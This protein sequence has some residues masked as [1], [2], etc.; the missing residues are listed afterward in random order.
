MK[1]IA[2]S[3]S[4]LKQ[5]AVRLVA[6]IFPAIAPV[7]SQP[8][9]L[10][11][12]P[13][14][15]PPN[16]PV[17]SQAEN[18]DIESQD[19]LHALFEGVETGIFIIDPETHTLVDANSIAARMV[20]APREKI[21]GSLCHKFVCPAEKGRC[22]VT[23]LGQTV[24][25]SERVLLTADGERRAIIK[26]VRRVVVAGRTQLL[27]SFL[28]ITERKRAETALK[29]RTAYL[30]SLIEV[31]P[32]GIVVLDAEQHV[33]IL[34]AAFEQLFH[35]TR[36]EAQG[37]KLTDLIIPAELESEAANLT[38][39]CL[40]Q[41]SLKTTTRRRRKDGTQVDVRVFAAPLEVDGKT[42]GFLALYEDITAQVHAEKVVAERHRLAD[43]AAQVGA[44]L[45][46]ADDLRQGLQNCAEIL[47]RILDVAFARV[48]TVNERENVLELQASAGMY[49]HLDGPHARVPVGLYK[50]GRIAK[51]GEAHLSNNVLEDTWMA[52]PAWARREGMVAFA[53]YPL[54]VK[55]RVSG[56]IAAFA[57][58][59]LTEATFQA[60]ASVA[61]SIAQ[62]IER[63]RSEESLRDSEDRFR[64]AF[65]AAP[66]G[67]CMTAPDGRF[68][69]ANAALC[70]MLGY[71]AEELMAGAWQQVTHPDDLERSR[72]AGVQ[73]SRGGSAA[74]ELEKRYIQKNGGIV[75][76]RV[77]ILPVKQNH[78]KTSHFITQIED[79]TLRK[80][81]EK[82]QAFLVSLVESS[83]DAIIGKSIDGTVLSW[84]HGAQQLYGYS[85]EEM[86][87]KSITMLFP[88]DRAEEAKRIMETVG[89][90]KQVSRYDTV[91]VRK[92]GTRVDV[93]LTLSPV[94]DDTGK[95][96]GIATIAHD[97][98]QRKRREQQ[99]HLQTA[100]LESAANGIL[101][102]DSRGII[103]WVNPA[104]TRLTGYSAEEVLG[105]TPRALKSG[106][107]GEFYYRDMWTTIL[108]GDTWHG[109]IVNRRKDGTLY[110]E[111]MTITP[112]RATDGSVH[113]FVAIKQDISE[114]KRSQEELLFKSTLL[115][116][117][118][119]TTIDGILVIDRKG[120]R[121]QSNRHFAEIFNIPEELL[122]SNDDAPML[123][124]VV[125]Q[126]QNPADFLERVQY[127]YAHE[128]EKA[129]D[130]VKFEDGRCIDR[131]SAPL[132]DPSGRYYGRI[133]Y[134]RDIT[135][136]KQAEQALRDNEQ[137]YREL[138]ENA[139]EIIF[140]SDLDGRF[141]SV[142]LAGQQ[143]FG[144]TQEEAAE[145]DVWRLTAPEYW[146]VLKRN[147]IRM[148]AGEVDLTYE[149]EATAKDGHRVRL[150][151]KPRIIY[152]GDKPVGIQGIARNITGRDIAEMELRQAQKLESVGRLASGIAHEINTPIQFVG[153]NTR[154]LE[155]SFAS[156][157]TLL[158]KF[159]ELRD[160]AAS[161]AVSPYLLREV[162]R[163]E[164]ESDFAYLLDETPRAIAQTM[165]GVNRVATIVRA[166]K[167][168]AHPESKEMAPADL[169][170]AIRST[171]TVARNEWKYVA[172]VETDFADLPLVICNV[173]DLNQVF[174]NLLVN[175]AH[176][177]ADVVKGGGKGRI[178]I[179]TTTEGDKVHIS[180][181]D[182]GSG[183]PESIRTK[184]FD[185]FF[186]TKEVG[187]GT[188]QGLAIARSV[189]MERHKGT[190]TFESEVGKGTT[191]HIRL[192]VTTEENPAERKM[193]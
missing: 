25:N 23:D 87:G 56:V 5:E 174:L 52:D 97:I 133:W 4:T 82:A 32:L 65:E 129:R 57:R 99:T 45:T 71:P 159:G 3:F 27:E 24:D 122:N 167:E 46:G 36:A 47:T 96:A 39:Q 70:A 29:E 53:G 112:V 151:V 173:G 59:P 114:R 125:S 77:K 37:V 132:L 107:Q 170:K 153:D 31:S 9:R 141:T 139:S 108:R 152:H 158:G 148:L 62:F 124:H 177:I 193:R 182:S 51:T 83:Q 113:H 94:S 136:R 68:L 95:V 180:I 60:F 79:I 110:D 102:A 93:T 11:T 55:E 145:M 91:R 85:S 192:P 154:F 164:E 67:M 66:Y 74:I 184:I 26:T 100:A 21:V 63:K 172:E 191:F 115:E 14:R 109:E 76:A 188:G 38:E 10:R 42:C 40:D 160:A 144:Y 126:V 163:A 54:K 157:K 183:I 117:E 121:V 106:N 81:A 44:A 50:I 111:E 98:T 138:F 13:A 89:L 33:E 75:W 178:T 58:Q 142:N 1:T 181:A 190:L 88:P 12:Q 146:D 123:Q 189:I 119:E 168:F 176:A 162:Q 72:K 116:T 187:R 7:S 128:S 17:C 169:N 15:N 90:G 61:D 185:P 165:E 134:F 186:T 49:T 8:D 101:I 140:T 6:R 156:L 30:D 28:D 120:R 22:P 16:A 127:L 118:A 73:L 18:S 103:Q 179:R 48:W 20:G 149:I 35:Y 92:D 166:M 69:N 137:R 150:E 155:D 34:N 175:A 43:L 104:F 130:E 86:I 161:G 80:Q 135:E 64:T 171:I 78:V 147:R 2:Q 84:N 105:Q 143:A 41:R 131:Y 19:R